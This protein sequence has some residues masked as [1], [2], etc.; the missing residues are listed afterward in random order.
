MGV[1]TSKAIYVDA[2]EM[3]EKWCG[4]I[5]LIIGK[6][7]PAIPPVVSLLMIFYAYFTRDLNDSD[8]R[9]FFQLWYAEISLPLV[10]AIK[11]FIKLFFYFNKVAVRLENISRWI[12]DWFLLPILELYFYRQCSYLRCILL[13]CLLF[14]VTSNNSRYSARIDNN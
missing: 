13:D 14:Y 9:L 12:F 10:F 5:E 1:E 8:Y 3:I 6:I 2:N 11:A 7:T 4:R